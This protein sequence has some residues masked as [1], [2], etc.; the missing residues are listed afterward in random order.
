MSNNIP[1]ID[2]EQVTISPKAVAYEL[3]QACADWGFFYVKN[4]PIPQE[5][6]DAIFDLE[7]QFFA[8]PLSTKLQAPYI[9][10]KNAGFKPASSNG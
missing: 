4:H 9:P 6:V 3:L 10:A 7:K 2:F 1:I 5:A 8:Q